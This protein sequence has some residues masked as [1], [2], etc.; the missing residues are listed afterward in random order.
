MAASAEDDV[1]RV[2]SAD[3]VIGHVTMY[4]KLL[5]FSVFAHNVAMLRKA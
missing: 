2:N 4:A 3:E 1:P 5:V